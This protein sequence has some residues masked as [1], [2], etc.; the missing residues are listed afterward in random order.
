M[1]QGSNTEK[2]KNDSIYHVNICNNI[3]IELEYQ[4]YTLCLFRKLNELFLFTE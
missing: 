2:L 1:D 3:F 4:V